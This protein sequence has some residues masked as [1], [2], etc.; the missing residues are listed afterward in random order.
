MFLPTGTLA[1]P[2]G[3]LFLALFFGLS[4][5][6]GM[7]LLR[8]D[9]ALL[10]ARMIRLPPAHRKGSAGAWADQTDIVEG[11]RRCL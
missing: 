11:C 6:M 10:A 8:T 2:Q 9:P 7:R 3:R 1:W 4:Q 5:A